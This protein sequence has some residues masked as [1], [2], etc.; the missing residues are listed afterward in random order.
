M[1][2]LTCCAQGWG[3]GGL[4]RREGSRASSCLEKGSP[5]SSASFQPFPVKLRWGP[6]ELNSKQNLAPS[7]LLGGGSGPPAFCRLTGGQVWSG[8]G[9]VLEKGEGDALLRQ[10]RL[11]EV[12]ELPKGSARG[13]APQWALGRL[14]ELSSPGPAPHAARSRFWTHLTRR[15]RPSGIATLSSA[16]EPVNGPVT[17]GSGLRSR[18]CPAERPGPLTRPRAAGSPGTSRG[19]APAAKSSER[20]PLTLPTGP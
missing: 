8:N 17:E 14:P 12:L 16:S 18:T 3:W 5:K 19:A 4:S 6:R 20:T 10:H 7:C 2:Q 9:T 15:P 1:Q 13:S 11:A